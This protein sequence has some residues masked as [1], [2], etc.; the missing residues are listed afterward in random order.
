MVNFWLLSGSLENWTLTIKDAEH[1]WAT[2]DTPNLEPIVHRV[3]KGDLLP[4]ILE[5]V[6]RRLFGITICVI[7]LTL[8]SFISSSV[9]ILA[10]DPS[11]PSLAPRSPSV[12]GSV[13]STSMDIVYPRLRPVM[14]WDTVR[15]QVNVTEAI[16][17]QRINL[18]YSMSIAQ[19]RTYVSVD[20]R[21]RLGNLTTG[22][23][24]A[25][26]PPQPNGTEVYYYPRLYFS[27]GEYRNEFYG[28]SDALNYY[29]VASPQPCQF[30]LDGV[31]IEKV[32]LDSRVVKMKTQAFI[33]A[34]S[35]SE[36]IEQDP[37]VA[38]GIEHY[39][40]YD[41]GLAEPTG[42]RFGYYLIKSWSLTPYGDYR[43][44]PF[45][46]YDLWFNL[47]I[48]GRVARI[49]I[50]PKEKPGILDY[51]DG[52]TWTVTSY[53]YENYTIDDPFSKS[54]F[55]IRLHVRRNIESAYWILIPT[56]SLFAILG[57]TM[58]ISGEN[59]LRNRLAAFASLFALAWS[60][61]SSL[62]ESVPE[63]ARGIS[64]IEALLTSSILYAV[65]FLIYTALYYALISKYGV[66]RE[67]ECLVN[68]I[69]IS[70][71]L[72]LM[73][74]LPVQRFQDGTT[75]TLAK[76]LP[77]CQAFLFLVFLVGFGGIAR[78]FITKSGRNA[79]NEHSLHRPQR[80]RAARL[81]RKWKTRIFLASFLLTIAVLLYSA[82]LP[83]WSLQ[84]TSAFIA[85][86]ISLVSLF[87]SIRLP[88]VV[89]LNVIPED[90][91]RGKEYVD[92]G[93]GGIQANIL[94]YNS[95][96]IRARRV[97]IKLSPAKAPPLSQDEANLIRLTSLELLS[98]V[99]R[100]TA[101]WSLFSSYLLWN[102][103]HPDDSFW[104]TGLDIKDEKYDK[105][106]EIFMKR[107]SSP[108]E[109]YVGDVSSEEETKSVTI[110]YGDVIRWA[111]FNESKIQGILSIK[112]VL[113]Y[114]YVDET[115]NRF[116][117]HQYPDII[118]VRCKPKTL[119]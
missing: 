87:N 103:E 59:G 119:S 114:G 30:R 36:N 31:W 71:V 56:L 70:V 99:N 6:P 12:I 55:T 89:E 44:Y 57:M 105:V 49:M 13:R 113:S 107:I 64:L 94:V 33:Y 83:G 10:L 85:I 92:L 67:Q 102:I 40:R 112:V 111:D 86:L 8:V 60:V 96:E 27:N 26:I 88:R 19:P 91:A 73:V 78:I 115:Q 50:Y 11:L 3:M 34:M 74:L 23:F 51:R 69:P 109:L 20:T 54:T 108:I 42:S 76:L 52:Y 29:P 80:M 116:V 24:E 32:D 93:D 15:I 4:R 98:K 21:V 7:A 25:A 117:S 66:L 104:V 82:S 22:S 46:E 16:G 106:T 79:G 68:F 62:G 48:Y 45:D 47:T 41:T 58:L 90:I 28:I 35:M 63:P 37:Y 18:M 72:C 110:P 97:T 43:K 5:V 61:Y 9:S 84:H 14:P 75:A 39:G 2:W 17:L 100:E 77:D 53:M 95:G 118:E 81:F 38:V 101:Q 65:V 1:L